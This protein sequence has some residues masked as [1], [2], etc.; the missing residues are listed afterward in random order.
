MGIDPVAFC[1]L[2]NGSLGLM[3]GTA[4]LRRSVYA[5]AYIEQY[6]QLRASHI[7]MKASTAGVSTYERKTSRFSSI[8]L[9][10]RSRDE[11]DDQ[12]P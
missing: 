10:K 8:R 9:Q 11:G 7:I 4:Q 6:N 2:G 1:L 5:I 3:N 12:S